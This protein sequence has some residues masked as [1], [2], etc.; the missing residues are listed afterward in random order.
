[1]PE[2][3]FLTISIKNIFQGKMPSYWGPPLAVCILSTP[4]KSCICPSDTTTIFTL[5]ITI[6]QVWWNMWIE[7]CG[8]CRVWK[9][10]SVK[11]A[12]CGKCAEWEMLGVESAE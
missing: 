2:I 10:Q 9:K 5:C 12:K 11:N 8:K 3:L 4:L 1:M 7:E 6:R